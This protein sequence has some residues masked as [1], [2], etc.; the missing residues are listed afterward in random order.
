MNFLLLM[1]TLVMVMSSVVS[2]ETAEFQG[3][4]WY[5]MPYWGKCCYLTLDRK[6][7]SEIL[8]TTGSSVDV[9]DA[10]MY[11]LM[12]NMYGI[13][14]IM[15]L[16]VKKKRKLCWCQWCML[17][18]AI[19]MESKFDFIPIANGNPIGGYDLCYCLKI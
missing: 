7:M 14:I 3:K 4:C 1:E 16:H 6:L 19:L 15:I 12:W 11:L 8:P 10:F 17:W 2:G 13:S 5:T 9:P 18:S